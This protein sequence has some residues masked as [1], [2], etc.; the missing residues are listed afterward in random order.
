MVAQLDHAADDPVGTQDAG[1]AATTT[2][3]PLKSAPVAGVFAGHLV[4]PLPL[5]KRFWQERVPRRATGR[6]SIADANEIATLGRPLALYAVSDPC[7]CRP[8]RAVVVAERVL[9]VAD[10][11]LGRE[12]TRWP[13]GACR[14]DA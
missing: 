14:Y 4:P 3:L 5:R 7:G 10:L 11:H 12:P 1:N 8:R 2:M 6:R 13:A 9:W